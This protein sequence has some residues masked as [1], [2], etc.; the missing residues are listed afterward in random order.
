MILYQLYEYNT[1]TD[2]SEQG[3]LIR[4]FVQVH[5]DFNS[6]YS[7]IQSIEFIEQESVIILKRAVLAGYWTSYYGFNWTQKQE[8]DFWE[9]VYSKNPNSGVAILTLAEA[10]RGHSIKTLKEVIDMYFRAIELNS[11]HYYS[12]TSEDL[13]ELIRTDND[14]KYQFF[15]IELDNYERMWTKTEF[16]EEYPYFIERC[17]GD[18]KM[19][20]YVRERVD[21]ILMNK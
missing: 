7:L 6:I 9:L 5:Y 16:E 3:K 18:Q 21:K 12:L 1:R 13:E 15:K 17:K 4:D 19:L 14:M 2:L 10:Y 8:I 11:E 20:D